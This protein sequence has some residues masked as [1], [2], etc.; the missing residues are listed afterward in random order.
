MFKIISKVVKEKRIIFF[1]KNY[2]IKITS[3]FINKKS[4]FV[5]T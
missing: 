1:K 3:K 2:I 4:D 5:I